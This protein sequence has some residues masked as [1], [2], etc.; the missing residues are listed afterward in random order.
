MSAAS[1]PISAPTKQQP[2]LAPKPVPA[3]P[4][5]GKP[6]KWLILLAVVAAG[7]FYWVRSANQ[8]APTAPIVAA[9]TAKITAGTLTRSIRVSGQTSARD[10]ANITGPRMQ[11]PDANREMVLE[12]TATAGSWVKKGTVIAVIDSQ[13]MQD[14]V[15]DLEDTIVAAQADIRKR[16][17]EQA[18][19]IESMQQTIRVTKAQV[20]KARLDYGASE[21]RTD[22]ER[23][24]LKLSLDEAEAQYKQ[25][26]TDVE[27]K[28][29]GFAA[30]LKVLDLTLERHTRHRNRHLNDIKAFTIRAPM[31]GLVV[32]SSIF[33]NNEMSQVQAGDR[34]F[35]GM[36]FMKIVNTNTMQVEG[37]VNQVESD[38]FRLGQ[39][40][41]ILFDAFPGMQFQGEV[42]TIGALAGGSPRGS[43]YLR[44]VPIRIKINGADPRLIPDLSAS[45]DVVI[46]SADNQVLAPR[47]ALHQ[48]GD[49]VYAYVK[50]GET[51]EKREVTLGLRND[52]YA[53]AVSGLKT[54]DEVRLN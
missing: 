49:K 29:A 38:D 30:D 27:F 20:D 26:Q 54:G 4:P 19:D 36:A 14:H 39:K 31:D 7:A 24:I 51:F 23:Q 3:G 47:A 32:M 45:A 17:A 28:M 12:K 10:F 42:H 35:P 37:A 33:R 16:K 53:A 25:A 2:I 48:E 1:H 34:I 8:P 22:I 9:K 50:K 44:T 40:A 18:I 43:A 5:P 6:W 15:D 52:I 11:G 13:S 41:R 46:E 21:V